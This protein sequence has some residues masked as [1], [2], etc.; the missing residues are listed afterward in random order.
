LKTDS[1]YNTRTNPGL[2]PTPIASPGETALNAALHPAHGPYLYF[3][4]IDKEGHAAFAETLQEFNRLVAQS[5][6]NGVQ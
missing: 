1:P 6:A 3:V 4:T 2:P 5:R